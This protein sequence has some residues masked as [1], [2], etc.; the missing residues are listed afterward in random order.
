MQVESER[1][2]RAVLS[3]ESGEPVFFAAGRAV[4]GEFRCS[5]CGYGVIVRSVL[6]ACPMCRGLVWQ[7]RAAS[8]FSR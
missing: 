4:S 3:S 8:S 6:P 7:D 2:E 5:E 1:S